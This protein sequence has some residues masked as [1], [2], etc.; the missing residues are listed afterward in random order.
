[1]KHDTTPALS[2]HPSPPAAATHDSPLHTITYTFTAVP[3]LA[4]AT[5]PELV[6]DTAPT[7]P[8]RNKQIGKKMGEI[9]AFHTRRR[10]PGRAPA[11]SHHRALCVRSLHACVL[12][13]LSTR[14]QV[15]C[16]LRD[17]ARVRSTRQT[18]SETQM[19][20]A[21]SLPQA[22]TTTK[23]PSHPTPGKSAHALPI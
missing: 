8:D 10:R 21:P 17:S 14:G 2:P 7:A 23:N 5:V 1:M 20:I 9:S 15:S 3:P 12:Q 4:A 13:T 6:V 18:F 16:A 19:A 11:Q 22:A